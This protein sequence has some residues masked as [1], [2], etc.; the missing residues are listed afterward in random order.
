MGQQP[1]VFIVLLNWNRPQDTLDCI[2]SLRK[3]PYH[4][5]RIVVVDNGSIDDSVERIRN[6]GGN[7]VLLESGTNLGFTGGNN[8]GMQYALDNGADYIFVLNNDTLVVDDVIE[9]MV[10]AAESDSHIGIVTPKICFHPQCNLIWFGGA[11]FNSCS[12]TGRCVGYT[13]EDYGQFDA[14]QDVPWATGCA[15][16]IRRS[17]IESVGYFC[18]DYFAVFEDLDYCFRVVNRGYRIVYSPSAVVWHKESKSAGG[19]DA[20]SYVYYQTRNLLVFQQRWSR[21][22][23]HLI[24]SHCY[25][26]LYF[27]KRAVW[28]VLQNKWRSVAGLCYG[29][30]DG[31]AGKVGR[32]EY[33]FLSV[34]RK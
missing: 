12:M 34:I 19:R 7:L 24:A 15:M 26:F 17:V 4:N 29:I 9:T 3:R 11:E 13:Q 14:A 25:A 28:F 8:L 32:R 18:D 6:A 22:M 27:V 23:V 31:L 33:A 1:I 20:P 2:A 21:N 30:R 5:S 10:G 16:L